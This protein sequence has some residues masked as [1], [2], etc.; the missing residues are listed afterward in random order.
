[1]KKTFKMLFEKICQINH[2]KVDSQKKFENVIFSHFEFK[3]YLMLFI[4]HN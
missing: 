4:T 1:M 3:F 2:T